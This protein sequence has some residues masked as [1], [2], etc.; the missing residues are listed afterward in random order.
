MSV[1]YIFLV[2]TL[3][4]RGSFADTKEGHDGVLPRQEARP[5]VAAAGTPWVINAATDSGAS[6]L[7]GNDM[8]AASGGGL[9]SSEGD[10]GWGAT[11]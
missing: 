6:S 11:R 4:R 2:I 10:G 7:G 5:A 1:S 9:D 8:R 3:A